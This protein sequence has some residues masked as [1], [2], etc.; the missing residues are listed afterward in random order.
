MNH[1]FLQRLPCRWL[2][3]NLRWQHSPTQGTTSE[4]QS[5]FQSAFFLSSSE[6]LGAKELVIS[7][8]Y[9]EVG[10]VSDSEIKESEMLSRWAD[11]FYLHCLFAEKSWFITSLSIASTHHF[12]SCLSSGR[13]NTRRH[14][15]SLAWRVEAYHVM[16]DATETGTVEGSQ[17]ANLREAP[18][19]GWN[20]FQR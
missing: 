7:V 18:A 3:G 14:K 1:E 2:P 11:E 4:F 12:S 13:K 8:S 9:E 17:C 5:L 15:K 20:R 16:G 6:F 10:N 19:T